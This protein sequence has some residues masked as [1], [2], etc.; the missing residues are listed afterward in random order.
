MQTV[1]HIGIH[2]DYNV[3]YNFNI[4]VIK[5]IHTD[6]WICHKWVTKRMR[7]LCFSL[8]KHF[9]I[10]FLILFRLCRWQWLFSS[11]R[12][13]NIQIWSASSNSV[14]C[15]WSQR[16]LCLLPPESGSPALLPPSGMPLDILL[17]LAAWCV[18]FRDIVVDV[19]FYFPHDCNGNQMVIWFSNT[20]QVL[21]HYSVSLFSYVQGTDG[22]FRK[23]VGRLKPEQEVQGHPLG[24]ACL[25]LSPHHLW[26][27]S[28]G[29]DGLL[30]VR[31]TASMVDRFT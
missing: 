2:H 27:A 25:A 30:C 10:D 26:L 23:H 24:P 8:N 7:L 29:H 9:I 5:L 4:R 17:Y 28:V 1:L 13:S 6:F 18:L 31:E 12:P 20:P 14:M 16:D 21:Y 22:V 3:W 11:W 15:P 19:C